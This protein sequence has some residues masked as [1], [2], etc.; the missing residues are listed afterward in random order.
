L[1][2]SPPIKLSQLLSYIKKEKKKEKEKEKKGG[3]FEAK[4]H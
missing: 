4:V 3:G 2:F 1:V